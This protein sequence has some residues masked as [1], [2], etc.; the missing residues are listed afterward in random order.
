MNIIDLKSCCS[1][2]FVSKIDVAYDY[3]FDDDH[4]NLAFGVCGKTWKHK[5]NKKLHLSH[6]RKICV[7]CTECES[8]IHR[9]RTNM[10]TFPL[11][12][13]SMYSIKEVS[14]NYVSRSI[15][16]GV[17]E[18]LKFAGRRLGST[19]REQSKTSLVELITLR[20]ELLHDSHCQIREKVYKRDNIEGYS[21][22][23]SSCQT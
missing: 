17:T 3:Q 5:T 2:R 16:C 18:L 20:A 6:R 23:N 14:Q 19:D 8:E 9:V 12:T 11:I 4:P 21:L 15:K 1:K 10:V 22:T 13:S 7:H